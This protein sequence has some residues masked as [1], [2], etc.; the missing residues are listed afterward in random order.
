MLSL[1]R[2]YLETD[3]WVDRRS[4]GALVCVIWDIAQFLTVGSHD[5]RRRPTNGHQRQPLRTVAFSNLELEVDKLYLI[6]NL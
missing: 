6:H 3:A 1:G 5:H 4:F 2:L